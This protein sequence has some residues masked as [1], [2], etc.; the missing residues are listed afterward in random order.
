MDEVA[1]YVIGDLQGC[2]RTLDRLLQKL[3]FDPAADRVLLVG[4]L[5]NRGPR[6]AEV[7]RWAVSLGD[8]LEAVL[9]N[10]DLHLIAR[11]LDVTRPRRRD[12][13]DDVLAAPDREEL[14]EWLRHRPFTIRSGGD[15]VIH[16]G[17]FPAWSLARAEE[18][19]AEAAAELR[20]Q[21]GPELLRHMDKEAP[22][23]W[24]DDLSGQ[25]RLTATIQSLTRLRV[26]HPDGTPEAGFHGP[27]VD[28]PPG[29]RPWF[30]FAERAHDDATVLFGHWSA[31][32]LY[33]GPRA[34]GLDTGCVW[35]RE[36]T[37]LRL[38]DRA[39]FQQRAC[40]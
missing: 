12:T 1:T 8:R 30:E 18:L 28:A 26:C 20:S 15:F 40:D 7:L 4:D 5:V 32:G 19:G 9:G 25:Q 14:V 16:G 22:L 31:L 17:L 27:P 21:R 10:H 11:H 2:F 37:A 29:T 36:L 24:R 6:S 34:I 23:A 13:L 3:R 35:G 33:R 38:E 39:I